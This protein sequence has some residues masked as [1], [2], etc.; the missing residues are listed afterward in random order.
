MDSEEE[1]VDKIMMQRDVYLNFNPKAILCLESALHQ[2]GLSTCNDESP[3]VFAKVDSM[4]IAKSFVLV[5][6]N[7]GEEDIVEI[8]NRRC[9]SAERTICEMILFNMQEDFIIEA[10]ADYESKNGNFKVLLEK[11][12]RYN[13]S[14]K[15]LQL[16]DEIEDYFSE[17]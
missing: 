12:N 17:C 16:I 5:P 6:N 4:R 3:F 8:R 9:T 1:D 14:N 15:V 2:N 7:F 11:A 10:L 13:V